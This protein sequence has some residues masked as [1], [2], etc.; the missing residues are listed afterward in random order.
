MIY[1]WDLSEQ[2]WKLVYIKENLK[3]NKEIKGKE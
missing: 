1:L 2:K 3:E